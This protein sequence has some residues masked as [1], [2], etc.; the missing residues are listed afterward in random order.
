MKNKKSVLVTMLFAV[1]F[2]SFG[3]KF[4]PA[5][6]YPVA[7]NIPFFTSNVAFDSTTGSQPGGLVRLAVADDSLLIGD[8]VYWSGQSAVTKSST[9]AKYDSIAGVVVGGTK[10]SLQASIAAADVGTLAAAP[11][12]RVWILYNG[13]TWV[14]NDANATLV[15]GSQVI[16]S[17][18]TAGRVEVRTTAID[19]FYRV[20]GK[21]ITGGAVNTN[22]LVSVNVK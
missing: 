10:Q 21:V 12:E 14:K 18:A 8:V 4:L 17:N 20:V 15:T 22:V 5:T 1:L 19:T 6:T 2:L 11:N 7:R 9:L 3:F 16:P 13:R